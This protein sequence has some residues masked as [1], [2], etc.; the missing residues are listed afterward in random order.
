MIK[1]FDYN[2]KILPKYLQNPP[3]KYKH[4]H[5]IKK[6]EKIL[7]KQ[8]LKP[9]IEHRIHEMSISVTKPLKRAGIKCCCLEVTV[10]QTAQKM[11]KLN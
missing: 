4:P 3:K 9:L 7:N 5:I 10:F 2:K 8:Y 1:D 6:H 11:P